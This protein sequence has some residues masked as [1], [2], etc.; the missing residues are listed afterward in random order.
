MFHH[1]GR[2]SRISI[3]CPPR[4]RTTPE[5]SIRRRRWL[6]APV[7]LPMIEDRDGTLSEPSRDCCAARCRLSATG[8]GRQRGADVS[9]RRQS[10]LDLG[11]YGEGPG[12]IP[13]TSPPGSGSRTAKPS[14]SAGQQDPA[15]PT[16]L[17]RSA[18][19]GCRLGTSTRY[20][21]VSRLLDELTLARGDGSYPK[22]IQRL[23]RSW[24]LHP[25]RLG[26][27]FA[28]TTRTLASSASL[29]RSRTDR[30]SSHDR[31][32]RSAG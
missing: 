28:L 30:T 16:W 18:S 12:E 13:A 8:Q 5:R 15:S 1:R 2:P 26:A 17:A 10:R 31:N 22:L 23:A 21:H 11:C 20:H 27:R 9:L 4:V 6:P 7:L 25:R 3:R 32:S 19:Y 14:S 24:L 29:R